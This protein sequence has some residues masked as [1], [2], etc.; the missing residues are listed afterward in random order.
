MFGDI[1]IKCFQVSSVTTTKTQS[2]SVSW[3]DSLR[4]GPTGGSRGASARKGSVSTRKVAAVEDPDTNTGAGKVSG[5]EEEEE[6]EAPLRNFRF[7]PTSVLPPRS[8]TPV[9]TL[10]P[11]AA[12]SAVAFG[13]SFQTPTDSSNNNLN[14]SKSIS[15]SRDRGK[16]IN[17]SLNNSSANLESSPRATTRQRAIMLPLLKEKDE[18]ILRL[19]EEVSLLTGKLDSCNCIS[20]KS[21]LAKFEE[22]RRVLMEESSIAKQNVADCRIEIDDCHDKIFDLEDKNMKLFKTLESE[23]TLVESLQAEI[24]QMSYINS[25]N[26]HEDKH[27]EEDLES[28]IESFVEKVSSICSNENLKI[29]VTSSNE[30]VKLNLKTRAK[31]KELREQRDLLLLTEDAESS[32]SR[33]AFDLFLTEDA[34]SSQSRKAFDLLLT[35]DA[36]SSRSRKAFDLLLTEDAES[37]RSRKARVKK[38]SKSK[39]SHSPKHS[40]RLEAVDEEQEEQKEEPNNDFEEGNNKDNSLEKNATLGMK[41]GDLSIDDRRS[42]DDTIVKERRVLYLN[43]DEEEKSNEM[44]SLFEHE[45]RNIFVHEDSVNDVNI[46]ERRQTRSMAKNKTKSMKDKVVSGRKLRM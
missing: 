26:G 30:C 37:S 11:P 36:E 46:A 25:K 22:E 19:E 32:R 17:C 27:D 38:P 3:I 31:S 33:K 29:S 35:E 14:S 34:E 5:Q 44:K 24:H 8:R 21:E 42:N 1:I 7:M 45:E 41:L 12:A 9:T 40:H 10:R 28:L 15:R 39:H 4:G 23:Q 13:R 43:E 16:K 6:T 20:M 2:L 18:K